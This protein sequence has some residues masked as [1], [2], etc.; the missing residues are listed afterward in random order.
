MKPKRL[1]PNDVL[2]VILPLSPG[3][4][5]NDRAKAVAALNGLLSSS[6]WD[7]IEGVE[8]HK[9]QV[10]PSEDKNNPMDVEEFM[11]HYLEG[12]T[13]IQ[14]LVAVLNIEST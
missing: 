10:I 3:H 2:K 7:M 4:T 12:N 11:Y 13:M 6:G 1:T 14:E 9:W 5:P 8:G